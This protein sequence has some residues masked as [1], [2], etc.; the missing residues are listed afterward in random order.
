VEEEECARHDGHSSYYS[1][2]RWSVVVAESSAV[3]HD[4]FVVVDNFA[5]IV[6]EWFV[7]VRVLFVVVA[8]RVAE[9]AGFVV[10][11]RGRMTKM[12]RA[13]ARRLRRAEL[14]MMM[15]STRAMNKKMRIKRRT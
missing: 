2:S 1:A 3:V 5:A 12:R 6:H 11:E 8:S 15:R 4:R 13:T 14:R 10:G 9:V 7:V